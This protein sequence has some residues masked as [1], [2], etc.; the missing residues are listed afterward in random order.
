MQHYITHSFTKNPG[1]LETYFCHFRNRY[2]IKLNYLSQLVEDD[3]IER[4]FVSQCHPFRNIKLRKKRV[5]RT[6]DEPKPLCQFWHCH[7]RMAVTF[8]CGDGFAGLSSCA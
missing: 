4:F 3:I 1:E 7:I 8:R 2:E 6:C 5:R